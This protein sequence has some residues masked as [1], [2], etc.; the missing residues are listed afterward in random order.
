[1]ADVVKCAGV[2]LRA[3]LTP[4]SLVKMYGLPPAVG[5]DYQ[6]PGY[7]G[8]LP[9]QL[10]RGPRVVSVGGTILGWDTTISPLPQENTEEAREQYHAKLANFAT[11]VFQSGDPFAL[12]WITGPPGAEV[13]RVA[14][15][16]YQSGVDEIEQLTPWAGRVAV[17]FLLLTPFWQ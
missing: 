12:T 1:M 2:D 5:Q 6:I 10:G 8:A 13:T 7:V 15:A 3:Y 9:A 16:R 17:E 11:T 14:T 4:M